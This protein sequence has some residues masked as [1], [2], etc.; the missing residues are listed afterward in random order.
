MLPMWL[1]RNIYPLPLDAANEILDQYT[2]ASRGR[3][4]DKVLWTRRL[5]SLRSKMLEMR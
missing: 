5:F 4:Y 2:M 3:S 1:I